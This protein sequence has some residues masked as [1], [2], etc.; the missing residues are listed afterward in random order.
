MS[1][2]KAGVSQFDSEMGASAHISHF[3]ALKTSPTVPVIAGNFSGSALD[4][5]VW[6]ETKVGTGSVTVER[7]VGRINTGTGS[8]GSVKL[9]SVDRGVFDAG[10]VTVYQSGV[11]AGTGVTDNIRRW[12]LMDATEQNGL[13]FE[14]NETTFRVVARAGGTDTGVARDSFNGDGDFSPGNSNNTYRIHYSAGRALFQ[15]AKAGNIVTL[16]TMVDSDFP[17]VEDLD[18]GLYYENTNAGSTT[19]TEMRVRGASSSVFGFRQRYNE[20]GASWS[21][22]FTDEIALNHVPGHDMLTKF[23]RNPDIDTASGEDMW[24]GGS[25]YTGF[26]ATTNEEIQVVSASTNDVGVVES[27]GTATG[28][29]STTLVDSG[30]TFVTDGVT[31]GDVVVN[32]TRGSHGVISA[33]TE[34]QATVH[35]MIGDSNAALTNVN[36]DSYRI[37]S[38]NG[39]GAALIR[40]NQILNADYE[41]QTAVYVVLNGTTN[42]NT[43]GV[44]AMRATRALVVLAG[45][46][47]SAAGDIT[48]RQASSTSNVFAVMPADLNQTTIG[49]YTVPSG[50]LM[51]VKRYR[52]SI[53][54]AN[55]SAGSATIAFLVRNRGEVFRGLRVFEVQTGTG[56]SFTEEGGEVLQPG[57][58]IKFR[59]TQVSDNNTV[60]EGVF[61]AILI[62]Q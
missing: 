52:V 33:I 7:G 37:V 35:S 56:T 21:T 43:S 53:T 10:Q 60:A 3:G 12:G 47:G 38:T 19:D 4:D 62:D 18:L 28:G 27:S 30:A 32:D 8:T 16:H 24:N 31:V 54:R 59:V 58:D 23:G 13:F 57:T 26:N 45:S 51:L 49:A 20:A 41:Q 46:G 44:T 1:L 39:T 9:I 17:L 5:K 29:T 50:K 15:R 11:Y 2:E 34:T 36:G 55:G 40:I 48:I 25:V 6:R 22:R 61:E 42:V 14:W